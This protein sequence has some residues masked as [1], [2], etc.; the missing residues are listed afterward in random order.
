MILRSGA[1]TLDQLQSQITMFHGPGRTY[2][3]QIDQNV[4]NGRKPM[5]ALLMKLSTR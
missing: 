3:L 4:T 2:S 1:L 5:L